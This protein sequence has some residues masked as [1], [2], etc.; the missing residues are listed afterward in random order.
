[1][2]D[3]IDWGVG[4]VNYAA[5]T[6]QRI[7]WSALTGKQQQQQRRQPGQPLD[8]SPQGPGGP[9]YVDRLR[10]WLSGMSPQPAVANPNPPVST[11]VG[12]PGPGPTPS[13]ASTVAPTA[14]TPETMDDYLLRR[15]GTVGSDYWAPGPSGWEPRQAGGPVAPIPYVQAGGGVPG[16]AGRLMNPMG[17]VRSGPGRTA[18]DAAATSSAISPMPGA[19]PGMA[20]PGTPLPMP[21]AGYF[22][23]RQAG[24]PVAPAGHVL[25]LPVSHDPFA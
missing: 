14:L 2:A 12:E 4:P 21:P 22:T 11:P 20:A 17:S 9:S 13:P 3:G 1:M 7:D 24:G 6:P 5:A 16:Y 15:Y 10:Y 18:A 25:L 23:P 19:V 8:I